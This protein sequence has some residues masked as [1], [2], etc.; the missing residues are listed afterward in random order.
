[1]CKDKSA[2]ACIRQLSFSRLNGA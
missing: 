2:R 1:M